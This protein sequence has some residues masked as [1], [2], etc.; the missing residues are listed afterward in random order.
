MWESDKSDTCLMFRLKC[1]IEL[2]SFNSGV[3]RDVDEMSETGMDVRPRLCQFQPRR[4]PKE[5]ESES[6]PNL[7]DSYIQASTL[8]TLT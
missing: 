5:E 8:H 1:P 3:F 6:V 7:F 2:A 4:E